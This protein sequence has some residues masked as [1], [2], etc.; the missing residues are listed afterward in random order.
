M[1]NFRKIEKIFTNNQQHWV[2]NGFYVRTY[3]PNPAEGLSLDRMSPFVLLDY[4]APRRFKGT[5]G[6]VGIGPHPHRGFETVTFAFEG[7][8]SH[9]DNKGHTGV[10]EPGDIQWMTAARGIL[11]KEYH[12]AES[13]KQD[14][15]LH[16]IQLWVNLPAAYKMADPNYQAIKADRMGKIRTD[17]GGCEITV[18]AG[19]VFGTKGPATTFSPMNIYK[20]KLESGKTLT[21]QE[22]VNYNTGL[23]VLSGELSVNSEKTVKGADFVLFENNGKPFELRGISESSEVFVLSGEPLN[24]PIAAMGPFVMNSYEEILQANA[25]FQNGAFGHSDF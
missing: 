9:G 24:E 18:Y 4:N 8:I 2:G 7:K 16:M 23:L 22:P 10:I 21:I 12:E 14:R 15:V 3:F 20:V 6:Q 5:N 25:D 17:D 11:H 19:D 13:A 1:S